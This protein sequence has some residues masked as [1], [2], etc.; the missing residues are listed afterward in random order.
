MK[1]FTKKTFIENAVKLLS[2][3]E[4]KAKARLFANGNKNNVLYVLNKVWCMSQNLQ[5]GFYTFFEP[6]KVASSYGGVAETTYMDIKIDDGR[7]SSFMF[8]RDS[9]KFTVEYGD[10]Q[11]TYIKY[12]GQAKKGK[13][14]PF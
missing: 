4:Q 10:L 3:T 7:I 5:D 12:D 13:Y 1:T 11:M 8:Y 14:V 2:E 6:H 9:I